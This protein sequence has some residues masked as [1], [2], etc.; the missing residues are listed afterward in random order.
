LRNL[1]GAMEGIKQSSHA[2]AECIP[3]LITPFTYGGELDLSA[4]DR[5]LSYYKKNSIQ[6]LWV[7]GTGGED[8]ALTY[9]QRQELARFLLS[10]ERKN[11]FEYMIGA[12]FYSFKETLTFIDLLN[13]LDCS[14]A[15]YMIY[16]QLISEEHCLSL[17]KKIKNNFAGKLYAYSSANWGK[18]LS[19]SL[20]KKLAE[21]G[22]AG[23][24][25]STSNIVNTQTVLNEANGNFEV[26][27]AVVK[28]LLP[29]LSLGAKSFTTVE[30]SV[31]LEDIT[32]LVNEFTA[33]KLEMAKECQFKLNKKIKDSTLSPTKSNFLRLAE[34]K[35]IMEHNKLCQRWLAPGYEQITQV[36][37]NKLEYFN[38]DEN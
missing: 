23:I 1:H 3:V 27:P 17:Y 31:F 11:M 28:Q 4:L 36:E 35:S 10:E 33:G 7:L 6:R 26:I 13:E 24:K 2:G 18:E 38:I 29:S 37:F 9:N 12:S 30:A 20:V 21:E 19:T 34:I 5:I 22:F 25:Y 16:N 14:T 8:M 32:S 15:H